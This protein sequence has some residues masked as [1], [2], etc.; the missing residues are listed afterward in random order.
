[1]K[2]EAQDTAF[3]QLEVKPQEVSEERV[4]RKSED[5]I[6]SLG[7]VIIIRGTER[8]D[9]SKGQGEE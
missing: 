5:I 6:E 2:C 1:M 3:L 7:F 8:R 9:R 4:G